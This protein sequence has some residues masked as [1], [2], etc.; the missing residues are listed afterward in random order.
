MSKNVSDPV[1]ALAAAV[2]LQAMR[3]ARHGDEGAAD[4]LISDG[5]LWLDGLG[6]D[7]GPQRIRARIADSRPLTLAAALRTQQ[8]AI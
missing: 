7:I 5:P 6:L 8:D 3:E 2:I 4:W 1:N